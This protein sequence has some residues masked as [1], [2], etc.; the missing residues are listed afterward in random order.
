MLAI[1]YKKEYSNIYIEI[2]KSF[3]QLFFSGTIE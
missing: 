3:I 2:M 1:E